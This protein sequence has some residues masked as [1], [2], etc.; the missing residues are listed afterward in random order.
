MPE[1][2]EKKSITINLRKSVQRKCRLRSELYEGDWDFV[3]KGWNEKSRFEFEF[4]ES[5]KERVS[6]S[7]RG[8]TGILKNNDLA[9]GGGSEGY[10]I[11]RTSER[12]ARVCTHIDC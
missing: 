2:R 8:K 5:R 9:Q 6:L 10:E 12:R 3:S 4:A 1:A 11:E 7:P